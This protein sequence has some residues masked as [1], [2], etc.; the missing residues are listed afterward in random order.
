MQHQ[1]CNI[2]QD[3]MF[4]AVAGQ[5]ATCNDQPMKVA[6]APPA[7]RVA[8]NKGANKDDGENVSLILLHGQ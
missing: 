3:E 4:S 6:R 5:G 1:T 7:V 8:S 2:K